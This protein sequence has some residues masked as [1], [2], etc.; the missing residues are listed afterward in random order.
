MG[1][2]M[3]GPRMPPSRRE[4][5]EAY[6]RAHRRARCMWAEG[7]CGGFHPLCPACRPLIWPRVLAWAL[8][9]GFVAW[10]VLS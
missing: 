3:T 2:P 4:C 5:L 7:D 1:G 6:D 9:L 10:R 8:V